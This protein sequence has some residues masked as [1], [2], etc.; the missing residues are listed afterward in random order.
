MFHCLLAKNKVGLRHPI[1]YISGQHCRRNLRR[2]PPFWIRSKR[3]SLRLIM[4][5]REERCSLYAFPATSN[6]LANWR[7]S[8][9]CV[10]IKH[11]S[12]PALGRN[13]SG[14][15]DSLRV[16]SGNGAPSSI[17]TF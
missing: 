4:A 2:I 10:A 11:R 3:Q 8:S 15:P 5:I 16:H 13:I 17:L 1:L 12:D 9:V 6:I 7:T 14:Y